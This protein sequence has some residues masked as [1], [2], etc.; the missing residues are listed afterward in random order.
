MQRLGTGT[1][2]LQSTN[3]AAKRLHVDFIGQMIIT[4]SPQ[5]DWSVPSLV[6]RP[7]TICDR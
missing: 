1:G 3:F 6:P 7:S 4:W 5:T 2:Y